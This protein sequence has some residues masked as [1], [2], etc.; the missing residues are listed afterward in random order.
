MQ[1]PTHIICG[2][3]Q[4]CGAERDDSKLFGDYVVFT[5]SNG[6]TLVIDEGSYF[7][8]TEWLID[9]CVNNQSYKM[10]GLI[11]KWVKEQNAKESK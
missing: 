7:Q 9:D 10:A 6:E 11:D 5:D 4:S 3:L 1:V 8:T 2:Y